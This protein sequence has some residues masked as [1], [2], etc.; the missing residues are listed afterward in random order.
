MSIEQ[1]NVTLSSVELNVNAAVTLL[2]AAG[3]PAVSIV[4]GATVSVVHSRS[5]GVRS[6]LPEG[7]IARTEKLCGPSGSVRTYG[8]WHGCASSWSIRHSNVA[9][10]SSDENRN[11]ACPLPLNASGAWSIRVSGAWVSPGV[12]TPPSPAPASGSIGCLSETL[13][14]PASS[15]TARAGHGAR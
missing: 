1:S 15:R 10:G 8:D 7:S 4:S 13:Q 14:P 2:S 11:V 9:R 12:S 3:G 6:S 5:A